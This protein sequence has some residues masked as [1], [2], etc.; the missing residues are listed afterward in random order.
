MTGLPPPRASA[1]ASRFIPPVRWSI[2]KVEVIRM[3]S[4]N[5]HVEIS[6]TICLRPESANDLDA[7]FIIFVGE[8]T[9]GF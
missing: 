9:P 8:Q 1:S 4:S 5:M 2:G 6:P 3:T 7:Y